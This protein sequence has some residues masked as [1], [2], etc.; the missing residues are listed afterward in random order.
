MDSAS[1][2]AGAREDDVT[3]MIESR[4]SQIPSSAYLGRR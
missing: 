4:T 3:G 2:I 1:R